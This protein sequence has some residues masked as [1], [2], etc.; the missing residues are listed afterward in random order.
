MIFMGV[1]RRED[2]SKKI[3]RTGFSNKEIDRTTKEIKKI[4]QDHI[5]VKAEAD[6][7]LL[8]CSRY[9]ISVISPF[10]STSLA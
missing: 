6:R 3:I 2:F 8:Q 5:K 10:S 1:G 4:S 7:I 9:V